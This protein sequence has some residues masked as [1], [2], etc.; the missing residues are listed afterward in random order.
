VAIIIADINDFDHSA[1]E[2]AT[3]LCGRVG[4]LA[5]AVSRRGRI[6]FMSKRRLKRH[7]NSAK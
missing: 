7:R 3:N 2:M 4:V 5:A 1:I 6:D